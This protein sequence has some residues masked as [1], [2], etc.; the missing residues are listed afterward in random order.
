MFDN[1]CVVCGKPL[2]Y[3]TI[4]N[5]YHKEVNGKLRSVHKECV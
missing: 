5:G 1:C 3:I 4:L 2:S